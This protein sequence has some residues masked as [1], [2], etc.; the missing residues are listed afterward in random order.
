MSSLLVRLRQSAV[1]WS[2]ATNVLRLGFYLILLPLLARALAE[3]DFGFYWVLA[4]LAAIVPLLD[5]GFVTAIDRSLSYAMGGATE[6]K[7]HGVPD[8]GST[9]GAPNFSLLWKLLFTTATVYR[10]LALGV[11]IVLGAWGT[12]ITSLRVAETS[13]ALHTWLAW[14]LT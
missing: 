12:F 4:N 5:L 3:P 10:L 1:V 9:P 6:L 2:W 8:V 7:A 14:G 11:L 13:S